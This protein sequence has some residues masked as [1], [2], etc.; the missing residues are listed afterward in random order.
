MTQIAR[1]LREVAGESLDLRLLST[2]SIEVFAV[3]MGVVR[4]V[5]GVGEVVFDH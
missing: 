1:D 3:G 5:P 2:S 4:V